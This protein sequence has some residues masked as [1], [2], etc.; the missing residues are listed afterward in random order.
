MTN[1][2]ISILLVL[3]L[4]L[5]LS[6]CKYT[7]LKNVERSYH[8]LE[9]VPQDG[10][11]RRRNLPHIDVDGKPY[12]VTACLE[13]SLS[14]LGLSRVKKYRAELD[15]RPKVD[16]ISG[17]EWQLRKHKLVFKFV[18]SLLDGESTVRFLEDNR[19]AEVVQ[20]AFLHFAGVRYHLLGFVVMPSHHHWVF[21]PKSDWADA[22]ARRQQT[23][24]R[25]RTPR[26]A[27]SHSIQSFTGNQC[28]KI[29]G[30]SGAFWQS[31]TFDHYAR[32]DDEL[33]RIIE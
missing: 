24:T 30:R 21:L 32:N 16:G 2:G 7:I 22:F 31:E 13:R 33:L 25:R 12:F 15:Q 14:S 10:V 19:L 9:A 29:L 5:N 20:N 3:L 11:F 1:C 17:Q 4:R 23:M 28:N 26:E 27:I 6:L 8:R 18:D